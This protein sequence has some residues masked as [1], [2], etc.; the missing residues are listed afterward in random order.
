SISSPLGTQLP[1]AVGAA[2]AAKLRGEDTVALASFGDGGTSTIGFHSALTFAGVW[3]S[4]VVFLCQNNGYA[5]SLPAHEQT[6]S[7]GYAIKGIAYGVRAIT[8]DGNDVFAVREATL[9]AAAYARAGDGPTLIE[10]VTFR[11]GG[12]STSDDPSTYVPKEVVEEWAQKD[13]IDRFEKYLSTRGLWDAEKG[14][15]IGADCLAEIDAAAKVAAATAPPKLETIFSDVYAE[16]PAH[17]RKQGEASFE[18]ANRLGEAASGDG[19]FPL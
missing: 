14:V 17:I 13:P 2:H 10:A 9:E 18:L 3:K 5:I 12:H 16:I 1:Q 8:V 19:A 15:Q 11:M 7:D 6:A 4:P